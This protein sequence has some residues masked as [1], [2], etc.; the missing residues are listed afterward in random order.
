MYEIARLASQRTAS[1]LAVASH[2]ADCVVSPLGAP[3]LS[4]SSAAEPAQRPRS[5]GRR[6]FR[7]CR[8]HSTPTARSSSGRTPFLE[9]SGVL[10]GHEVA[11]T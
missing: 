1:G 3:T 11:C 6:P 5:R 10:G 8:Y 4:R 2:R 7:R 9:G